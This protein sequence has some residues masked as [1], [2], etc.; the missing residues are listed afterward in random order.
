MHNEANLV[1]HPKPPQLVKPQIVPG[2]NESMRKNNE[3]FGDFFS[4]TR[5]AEVVALARNTSIANNPEINWAIVALENRDEAYA[6]LQ[7]LLVSGIII[8]FVS[9]TLIILLSSRFTHFLLQPLGACRD[10]AFPEHAEKTASG[11]MTFRANPA[12]APVFFNQISGNEITAFHKQRHR[13]S[14]HRQCYPIIW[15]VRRNSFRKLC[16]AQ[17]KLH[18]PR[19][20]STPRNRNRRKPRPSLI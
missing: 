8:I 17:T 1:I 7:G 18:S 14:A 6:G 3:Y 16:V 15:P 4:L 20:F 9:A 2:F 19:T 12:S 11:K 5:E 10:T 13:T